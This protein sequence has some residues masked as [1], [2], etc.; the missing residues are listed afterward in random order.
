[1]ARKNLSQNI[2]CDYVNFEAKPHTMEA[3]MEAPSLGNWRRCIATLFKRI[4]YHN[5]SK[6]PITSAAAV[7]G[8]SHLH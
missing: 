7:I 2:F 8:R 1:M 6:P 4:M 5:P 3:T